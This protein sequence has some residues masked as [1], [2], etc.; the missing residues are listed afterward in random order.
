LQNLNYFGGQAAPVC[1]GTL[2][3]TLV[4]LLGESF[5]GQIHWFNPASI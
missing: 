3:Q 2:P 4:D 5:D 1:T